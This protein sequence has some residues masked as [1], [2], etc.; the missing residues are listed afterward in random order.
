MT[1]ITPSYW[2][3]ELVKQSF[4]KDYPV[5][6]IN[7]GI[8][9]NIFKPTPGNFREKMGITEKYMILAVAFGWGAR[10]GL[11]AIVEISA[12]L[13]ENYRIV[14]VGTNASV[15]KLLSKNIVSVHRTANQ[16]GLAEIYSAADVFINT[17][18]EENFPAVNMEAV[19]CGTPVVTFDSGGSKEM[20]DET[21]G[22]VVPCNDI[23]AMIRQIEEICEKGIIKKEDCLNKANDYSNSVTCEKYLK[24][25]GI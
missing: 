16:K 14:L 18:Q 8:D 23:E 10:K 17:T 3:G 24:E 2:L 21:C 4:F 15:D 13:N 6:V 7:N 25:Y 9:L 12:L 22:R 11:D 1:V 20:L 19:A 5:K